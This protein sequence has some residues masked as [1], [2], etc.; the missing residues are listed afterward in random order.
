MLIFNTTYLVENEFYPQWINWVQESLIPFM[1]STAGFSEPQ[2]A[3][4][5]SGESVKETSY[6][7][8]FK[9]SDKSALN[10]WMRQYGEDFAKLCSANFGN[11]VLFFSTMLELISDD[12]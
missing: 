3:K 12:K 10:D 5:L 8:Q 11:H 1:M 2:I 9:I 6:S 7:V 4:V